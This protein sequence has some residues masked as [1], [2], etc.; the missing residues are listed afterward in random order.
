MISMVKALLRDAKGRYAGSTLLPMIHPPVSF[1]TQ[2]LDIEQSLWDAKAYSM[3]DTVQVITTVWC[4]VRFKVSA[5]K[6]YWVATYKA[7]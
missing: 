1:Q 5:N 3:S 7:T 4:L 2:K 6:A